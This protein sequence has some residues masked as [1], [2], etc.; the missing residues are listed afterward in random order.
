MSSPTPA[1]TPGLFV[2]ET[3]TAFD[4]L[5]ALWVLHHSRFLKHLERAQQ[6]WTDRILETNAFDPD[7]YPDLY[8]VVRRVDIE[9]LAPLRGVVPFQVRLAVDRVREAALT[10]RF[11]FRSADGTVLHARGQR[12]VCRLSGRT[13][14]PCG[15]TAPFRERCEEL[16]R[17][18]RDV[19]T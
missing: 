18:G 11:A 4:E 1:G 19:E 6:A 10:V 14:Q 9:F 3:A 2:H 15:W 5:D 7:R 17:L 8:V 13:H 12:T 16:A